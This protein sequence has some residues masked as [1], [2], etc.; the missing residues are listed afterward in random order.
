VLYV[1]AVEPGILRRPLFIAGC[2]GVAALTIALVFLEL[3]IRG[4]LLPAPLV[5]GK[6]ATWDGFWY[7]A[8]AEQFRGSL[9]DVLANLPAKLD[10]LLTK[11][12][13]WFGVLKIA[14]PIAFVVTAWRLPRYALLTGSAML[15]TVLFN[16]A[17]SNADI[18]RYYLGP[19]LWLWTWLA[20]L[21]SEV[22]RFA[23]ALTVPATR[24]EAA[25]ATGRRRSPEI[26]AAVIVAV[27]LLAPSIPDLASRR[28]AADRSGDT[29]AVTWLAQALPAL[30]QNAVVVSWWSTSTPLWYAQKVESQRPD[31]FIVDDRTMLDLDLGRAPD[32]IRRYLAEGRPVYAI[33]L[34]GPDLDE[35][36][37][38]FDMTLVASSSH[39]GIW[40]VN[41]YGV[42]L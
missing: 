18:D 40:K 10:D 13:V 24:G 3:P 8:L 11:A 1:L 5:Y 38:Q 2:V 23:T 25:G 26:V 15:I 39:T 34:E 33:R 27:V 36:K 16:E 12:E 41:G 35:L 32:V 14:V 21:A 37:R 17:Y 9:G 20:I 31:I 19:V 4:G 6:P 29:G 7:V 22:A 42:T 30:E 28:A